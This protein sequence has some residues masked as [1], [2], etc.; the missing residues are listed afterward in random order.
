MSKAVV[1]AEKLQ[2]F[3]GNL[4]RF[5]N[6][7]RERSALLHQQFTRLSE[8]W[9]DQEQEKFSEEFLLM[10]AALERFAATADQQVP[11]LMRKAAAIQHYLDG[12]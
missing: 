5:T 6:E 7:L 12:R 1:D 3:A 8:T 10:L 11:T 4:N 9:R 2:Q